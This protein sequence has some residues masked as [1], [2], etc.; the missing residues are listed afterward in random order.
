MNQYQPAPKAIRINT[1]LN[2]KQYTT[3]YFSHE[4]SL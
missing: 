4:L 1:I 2:L 3:Y